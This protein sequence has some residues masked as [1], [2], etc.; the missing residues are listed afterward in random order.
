VV[1]NFVWK[2]CNDILP[3]K[4]SLLWRKVVEDPFY[5]FCLIHPETPSHLLWTCPSSVVVWQE[6]ARK[7]QKLTLEEDDS[8][9]FIR[10][11]SKKLDVK[12]F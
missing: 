5:P 7:I 11:L 2:V 4:I 12:F 9:G 6:S 10:E 1:K 3:T 8:F